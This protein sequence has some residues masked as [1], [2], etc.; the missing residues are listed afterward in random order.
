MFEDL[1]AYHDLVGNLFEK[2]QTPGEWARYRL[3]PEQV[4]FYQD[5]GYLA[6][7]KLLN[8]EQIEVLRKELAELVDPAH[9]GNGLFYEFNS[10]E[11]ADPKKILFHALGAW[12]ITPGF[13]DLLWNPAFCVPASQLLAGPVRFWHDQLFFKPSRHG[14]EIGRAHV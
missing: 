8:D 4:Q 2:P 3:S 12:R 1:S 9:P 13:H 5:N 7:I 6:G 14:G 10:N 11:S